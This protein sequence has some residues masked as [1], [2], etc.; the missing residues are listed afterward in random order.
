MEV[1]HVFFCHMG[2][3]YNM[4]KHGR[5]KRRDNTRI[6]Q[7]HEEKKGKITSFFYVYRFFESQWQR[8]VIIVMNVGL[9]TCG[10]YYCYYCHYAG[11]KA[12]FGVCILYI[13]M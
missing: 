1:I 13:G 8:R 10:Y 7:Q 9:T 4:C 3:G 2:V 5:L 6:T 12:Y 11:L